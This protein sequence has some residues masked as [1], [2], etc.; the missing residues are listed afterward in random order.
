MAGYVN[1]YKSPFGVIVLTYM[2]I[3]PVGLVIALIAALILK[4]KNASPQLATN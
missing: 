2:E 3:L 4:R 1:M